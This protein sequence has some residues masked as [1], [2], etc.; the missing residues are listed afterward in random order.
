[1]CLLDRVLHWDADSI[2]CLSHSCRK[3]TNPLRRPDGTL[4]AA[5]GVELAAQAM[6]LHGRLVKCDNAGPI[7]HGYLASL[8]EVRLRSQFLDNFEGELMINV[9][10]L[11]GDGRSATYYFELWCQ[12]MDLLTGRATVVFDMGGT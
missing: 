11:M 12:N 2:D 4:G 10:R 5:C 3:S 7:T 9:R 8:R 1:M 6:A